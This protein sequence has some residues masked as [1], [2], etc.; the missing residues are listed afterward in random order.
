ML[1][2]GCA[3]DQ[4]PPPVASAGDLIKQKQVEPLACTDF[5]PMRFQP[6]MDDV[7]AKDVEQ[8]MTAHPADPIPWARGT[9]GDTAST[10]NEIANYQA[11]RKA[12]GCKTY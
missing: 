7:T 6:G 10:R 12:I 2:A 3:T 11:R 4:T 9:I 5:A 1:A 8:T